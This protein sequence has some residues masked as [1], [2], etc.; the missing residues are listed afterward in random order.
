LR[1]CYEPVSRVLARRVA[2]QKAFVISALGTGF[3][4]AAAQQGFATNDG[5]SG[6]YDLGVGG[7]RIES[8][9]ARF[10]RHLGPRPLAMCH[11]GYSDTTLAAL[12]PM[13]AQ[14]DVERAFLAGDQWVKMLTAA[15]VAVRPFRALPAAGRP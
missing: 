1:S 12:D 10:I 15:H 2:R 9:F 11:P 7:Y 14:R 13:T 3:A 4:R 6:I 8:L 5:F